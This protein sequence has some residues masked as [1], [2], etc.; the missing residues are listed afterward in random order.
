MN[1]QRTRILIAAA[2]TSCS[3]AAQAQQT[4]PGVTLYGVA[5]AAVELSRAG[6]GTVTRVVSGGNL[7]SRWGVR[8]TED[9]GNGLNAVFRLEAGLTLDD[10]NLAQGGRAWGR[11]ASVGLSS[12]AWG[13]TLLGRLPTPYYQVHNVVDAFA[14]MGS[15]GLP[16][17]SRSETASRPLLPLQVAARADNALGYTSPDFG[18]LEFRVLGALGEGSTALGR[19]YGA[20]AR[21]AGGPI[22]AAL[23]M[24]RQ[25]GASNLNGSMQAVV[26]GGSYDFG[27][28][29]VFAG[30]T[31]EKNSCTTCTGAMARVSGASTSEFRLINLG[32]RMP[33]GGATTGIAQ[34]T[35][36]SD[37]SVYTAATGDRDATWLA[38]G[39]E[40]LLSKRTMIYG[41]IGSI[42][43]KNGS[44]YALGS[45]TALQP[46]NAVGTGNPR[47]TTGQIGIRHVF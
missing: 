3:F 26:A 13:T 34:V 8:G 1:K 47:A 11:E 6:R 29:K 4:P 38:I 25:N 15:G 31:N 45:G 14:W 44:L 17:V 35:R 2:A 27:V 19:G 46:A 37:R 39:A 12:K 40:Y 21:Y 28:A 22:I 20:S 33:L 43:N 24:M 42:G 36:V 30:Y 5:D 16:S 7:G 41:S 9:L 18:G 32:A 10:G 23:G